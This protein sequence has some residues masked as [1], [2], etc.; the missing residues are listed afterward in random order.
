MIPVDAGTFVIASKQE[1]ILWIPHLVGQNQADSLQR[2]FTSALIENSITSYTVAVT[3]C[4][5]SPI[6]IVTKEEKVSVWRI[7]DFVKVSQQV[8]ILS[9]Q[10]PTDDQGCLQLQ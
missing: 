4:I 3:I 5:V 6:N 10:V 7:S 9:V 1:D 2:H 8:L